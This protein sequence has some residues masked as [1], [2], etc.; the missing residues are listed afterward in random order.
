MFPDGKLILILIAIYILIR[1]PLLSYLPFV[2]DESIYSIM[3]QEQAAHPTLI[4]TLFGYP[5]SWKPML[6]FWTYS[7]ITHVTLALPIPIEAAFRLPSFLF[8]LLTVPLLYLVIKKVEPTGSR[9][10]A[11]FST[12]IF[13]FTLVSSYPQD[14]LLL[15]SMMFF[16]MVCALYLYIDSGNRLGSY[17]FLLAGALVF[18]AFFVK[19]LLV[20]MV[21]VLA[22][23][24]IYLKDKFS[25]REPLF[26][27]SLLAAP[28]AFVIHFMLLN[29][30]GLSGE[31]YSS[32]MTS[33]LVKDDIGA[34]MN[35]F[36]GSMTHFIPGCGIW[37]ALSL[38]G[39]WLYGRREPFMAVWYMFILFP[40]ISGNFMIWYYLPVMPAIAYFAA[41]TLVKHDGEERLDKFFMIIFSMMLLASVALCLMVYATIYGDYMPQ[42]DV[43]MMMA[44]KENVLVLGRYN[45]AILTYKMLNEGSYGRVRDVGWILEQKNMPKEDAGALIQDY[46]KQ[47]ANMTDGSFSA[48][49]TAQ[50][51]SFRKDTNITSFDYVVLVGQDAVMPGNYS[52]LY[53][54]SNLTIYRLGV[55]G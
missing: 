21:P 38:A 18:V 7:I 50:D 40:L 16:L 2:Q 24:Y 36:I 27:I 51:W 35:A 25:I 44:G 34:T 26:W 48:M 33:H 10:V 14:A 8:G 52:V 29:S 20:F 23:T 3:I 41:L 31:L 17:R 9:A 19:L 12:I 28:L 5:M 1:L 15:D 13:M 6:F 53:N 47:V 49:F 22:L 42:K 54:K 39:L 45:P 4:P 55:G 43:G 46:H 32:E 37:F 11:F 30:A